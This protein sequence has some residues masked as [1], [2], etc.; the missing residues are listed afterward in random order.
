MDLR[1]LWAI[2]LG[3]CFFLLA[4]IMMVP[5]PTRAGDMPILSGTLV[6]DNED[7]GKIVLTMERCDISHHL[8]AEVFSAYATDAAGERHRGCWSRDGVALN[9]EWEGE[10]GIHTWP[11]YIFHPEPVAAK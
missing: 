6:V 3:V 2:L 1:K 4:I 8:P 7:G 11:A 10:P 5:V 9:T